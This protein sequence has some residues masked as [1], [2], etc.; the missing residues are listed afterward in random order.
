MTNRAQMSDQRAE[1][2]RLLSLAVHELRTP[3]SV[4]S[5]YLR[6]LQRDD[7][8]TSRQRK[9]IDDANQACVRLVAIIGELSDIG[10]LDDGRAVLRAEPVDLAELLRAIGGGTAEADDR[11]VHLECH[12]PADALVVRGDPS[13]LR[14]SFDALVRAVLREQTDNTAVRL[15]W[16]RENTRAVIAIGRATQLDSASRQSRAPFDEQRG[17]LGLALPIA[18]RVIE[19]HGGAIWSPAGADGS[20]TARSAIFVELPTSSAERPEPGK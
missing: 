18:R 7:T 17:G 3:L 11:R 20:A 8:L 12:G 13:R 6:I 2:G 5:G 15:E 16:R 1:Y 19:L 14:T 4:A 9:M 10:Q